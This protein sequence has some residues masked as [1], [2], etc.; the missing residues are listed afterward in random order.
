MSALLFCLGKVQGSLFNA[1][2]GN[3]PANTSTLMTLGPVL[4]TAPVVR[5][6]EGGHHPSTHTIHYRGIV[7]Q[8]F[9]AL[10]LGACSP[11]PHL[12]GPALLSVLP[13]G[14]AGPDV[15][16]A[17]ASEGQGQPAYSHEPRASSPD[18]C[19]W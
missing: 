3:G 2:A 4:L 5:I 18:C 15:P 11:V 13:R 6:T 12:S 7:G 16:S 14:G 9:S 19:W 1:A 17:V 8:L 10:A